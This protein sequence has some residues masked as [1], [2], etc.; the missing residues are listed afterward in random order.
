MERSPPTR[1]TSPRSRTRSSFGCSDASRSPIS[2]MRSV[3]PCACSE[4]AAPLRHRS[5]EGAALVAEE[6]RLHQVRRDRGAIEDHERRRRPRARL[7]ERL[8][9]RFLPRARLTLDDHRHARRRQPL[10]H[11]V[12][13][14][15]LP[16][17]A[18]HATEAGSLR[19]P[20]RVGRRRRTALDG[21]RRR[22]D[23]HRLAA[24]EERRRH[25]DPVHVRSVGRPEVGDP[26]PR[27]DRLERHMPPRQRRVANLQ[28]AGGALADVHA[29]RAVEH[30]AASAGAS[31]A[32]VR[33]ALDTQ[34]PARV[35]RR[36][37]RVR[38][39]EDRQ[40]VGFA[41]R[42]RRWYRKR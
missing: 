27:A 19:Q 20:H 4:H 33:T 8:G 32:R 17:P 26:Q 1:R 25:R 18:D 15:H 5:G 13:P 36:R 37:G 34:P 2:S 39:L 12:Q 23:L 24:T 30:D 3:P 22:A 21:Q 9:Q 11:G 35:G 31:L 6:L 29:R 40:E 38:C 41:H 10:A 7:V 28:L 14:A 16:A 42:S